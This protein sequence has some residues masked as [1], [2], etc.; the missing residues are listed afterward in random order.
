MLWLKDVDA[1]IFIRG[2][3]IKIR[4]P[5]VGEKTTKVK[6]PMLIPS[7]KHRLVLPKD[8]R[9]ARRGKIPVQ[10]HAEPDHSDSS[11]SHQSSTDSSN[12]NSADLTS[13]DSQSD[14]ENLDVLNKTETVTQN[15]RT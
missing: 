5:S 14:S 9:P 13:S 12:A 4:D 2:S 10:L 8:P 11:S 1:K 7:V 3:Y 15:Q 6:C